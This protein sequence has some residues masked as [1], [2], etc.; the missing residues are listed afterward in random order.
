MKPDNDMSPDEAAT[1]VALF[2]LMVI[3]AV[4]IAM[5]VPR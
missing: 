4:I 2:W 5:N 3:A 1:I